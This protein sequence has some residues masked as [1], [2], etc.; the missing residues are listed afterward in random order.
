[1][2]KLALLF[3]YGLSVLLVTLLIVMAVAQTIMCDGFHP[4][5]IVFY[6]M[7]LLGVAIVRLA[8]KELKNGSK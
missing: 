1:M 8:K 6:I 7:V 4:M 3:Q 2:N 5:L